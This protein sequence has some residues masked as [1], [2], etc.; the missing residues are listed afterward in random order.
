MQILQTVRSLL[1][2]CGNDVFLAL[3]SLRTRLREDLRHH[4][5]SRLA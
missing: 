4:P 2:D 3:S 5:A 1:Q